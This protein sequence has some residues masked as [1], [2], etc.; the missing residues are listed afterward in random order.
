MMMNAVMV[1]NV[2]VDNANHVWLIVLLM[3]V[4]VMDMFV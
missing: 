2:L 1:G 4:A 3:I